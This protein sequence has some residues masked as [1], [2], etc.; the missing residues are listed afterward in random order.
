MTDS[1]SYPLE[2]MINTSTNT[3]QQ[4]KRKNRYTQQLIYRKKELENV[5][6][7]ITTA[8]T[9]S[10]FIYKD[11]QLE[12]GSDGAVT[13]ES[14]FS[15]TKT[16][17]K[18]YLSNATHHPH[19]TTTGAK[20]QSLPKYGHSFVVRDSSGFD[21]FRH[22]TSRAA[23]IPKLLDY[24]HSMTAIS[25]I[26]KTISTPTVFIMRGISGSGKSTV[27]SKIN[28][29]VN[30]SQLKT[31]FQTNNVSE[32]AISGLPDLPLVLIASADQYFQRDGSYEFDIR[33]LQD[34][35]EYCQSKVVNA[36]LESVPVL[37]VD[38]T[39]VKYAEMAYY[40]EAAKQHGYRTI[41]VELRPK[42]ECEAYACACRNTHCVDADKVISK[43]YAF[44][45]LFGRAARESP[46]G[47]CECDQIISISPLWSEVDYTHIGEWKNRLDQIEAIRHE[48][49]KAWL[50][51]HPPGVSRR[52]QKP[53]RG[54]H[55]AQPTTYPSQHYPL[56]SYPQSP[57]TRS[58][59][60]PLH[61]FGYGARLSHNVAIEKST[62]QQPL[63]PHQVMRAFYSNS[64]SETKF[65]IS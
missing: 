33:Q 56:K 22:S 54:K 61:R 58:D 39:N 44:D 40:L 3:N 49:K 26:I 52:N 30:N 55:T 2:K 46:E 59:S 64:I 41:V 60:P 38:N 16:I 42:D 21:I 12:A 53:K 24:E 37:I 8:Q 15:Q 13:N 5:A 17:Y 43:F 28:E 14:I 47:R 34:A 31:K 19:A 32:M 4:N 18:D 23:P 27:A 45:N 50:Q 29:L 62:A 63:I 57:D 48:R 1:K 35:H 65:Q 11:Q 10:A 7:T 9:E 51:H 6:S 25:H 36:M 20:Y